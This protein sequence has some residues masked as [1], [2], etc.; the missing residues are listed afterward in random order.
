MVTPRVHIDFEVFSE[1]SVVDVGLEVYATHP[2]TTIICM[3]WAIEGG[4]RGLWTPGGKHGIPESYHLVAHNA[5]FELK[6]IELYGDLLGLKRPVSIDCTAARASAMTYPRSLEGVSKA[7]HLEVEKDMEGKAVMLQVTKP[8]R[9]SKTNPSTTWFFD[10]E[11]M[12]VCYD[13]CENDVTV[14]ELVDTKAEPLHP[15][16]KKVF[17][18]D[19]AINQRG[20][21]IDRDLAESCIYLAEEQMNRLNEDIFYHTGFAVQS[22]TKPEQIKVWMRKEGYKVPSLAKGVLADLLAREDMPEHIRYAVELRSLGAMSSVAKYKKILEWCPEQEDRV[23]YIL[24]YHGAGTGRWTGKGPQLHNLPRGIKIE[25]KEQV[26]ERIKTRDLA[27]LDEYENPMQVFS[28]C[29]RECFTAS[30]GNK[31]LCADFSGVE[32]RGSAWVAGEDKLLGPLRDGGD[33]YIDMATDIYEVA[34]DQV[35]DDQR[36]TGKMAILG[37][38]YQMGAKTFQT[39]AKDNYGV[40]LS[41]SFCEKVQKTYRKK[42]LGI[43]ALWKEAQESFLEAARR[44]GA[45]Q[46]V[47]LYD[48]VVYVYHTD[49]DYITATLPSGRSLYYI[50]PRIEQGE[51]G[52]QVTYMRVNSF[53]K[54]WE[55]RAAYGGL[56]VENFIQA[57]CRDLLCEAMFRVDREYPIVLTVHDEIVSDVPGAT[58]EDLSRF[59]SLMEVVPS[60]AEGFPVAAEGWIGERYH[61]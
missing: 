56:L 23:R 51:Y 50:E 49:K 44:P 15:F 59:I 41:L 17:E 34:P 54:Q 24:L 38:G 28:S 3:A 31:L 57:L 30:P 61:K 19:K 47:G 21:Y 10:L 13:Y 20:V 37:L 5:L 14:E 43:K 52:P 33:V 22:V 8:R 32:T 58:E 1:V 45:P 9:P 7:M 12:Q 40:E 2:S 25:D 42:Y 26:I 48:Q 46:Y 35:T 6:F 53:T 18:L 36:L 55:R 27:Q 11:K 29:I 39:Q 60:W 16:E 4:E